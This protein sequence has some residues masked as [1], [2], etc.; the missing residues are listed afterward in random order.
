MNFAPRR[1]HIP[2]AGSQIV[3]STH[4]AS[5]ENDGVVLPPLSGAVVR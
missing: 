3:L 4:D 2:V 5:L 1:R